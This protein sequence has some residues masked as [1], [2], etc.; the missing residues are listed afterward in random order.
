MWYIHRL[1]GEVRALKQTLVQEMNQ[2]HLFTV[3]VL[4]VAAGSGALLEFVLN[5]AAA[6]NVL[7]V[8]AE[9]SGD[10][11]CS[12]RSKGIPVVQCN[13]L[14]LPFAPKSFD[15]V[16]CTLFLHHLSSTRAADALAE[17]ASIARQ[18]IFVIDLDRRAIPYFAYRF[19]GRFL[20]Q[21]FTRDDGALSILRSYRPRELEDIARRAGLR[22]FEIRRSAINR[23]VLS[24]NT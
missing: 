3:S 6:E 9:S 15:Y 17:M 19:F 2:D 22:N 1:F 7:A 21:R 4:D 18:K 5:E 14:A 8:G 20:L 24:A 23:L 16:F 11:A 13:A 10:A 12:I